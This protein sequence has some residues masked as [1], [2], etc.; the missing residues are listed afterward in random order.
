MMRQVDFTAPHTGY[1]AVIG[2][3]GFSISIGLVIDETHNTICIEPINS[4]G[5][6]T[7]ARI[8]CPT[9]DLPALIAALSAFV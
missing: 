5:A 4:S 3:N 6:V 8:V 2:R 7:K 9:Q 1:P